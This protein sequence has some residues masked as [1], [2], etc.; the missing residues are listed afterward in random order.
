M[1][2]PVKYLH[3]G[4]HN[5]THGFSKKTVIIIALLAIA[6]VLVMVIP[7]YLKNVM[8]SVLIAKSLGILPSQ[9]S[10][11]N[12]I[13]GYVALLSY[14][15]GGYFA[16][17]VNLK[18]LTLFGLAAVGA[19]SIWYAFIPFINQGKIVQ[20][21]I[22][23]AAWSFIT[24]FIFWSALWKI[25][26]EQGKP[27][28]NGKLNGLHGSLNGLIGS[29]LIALAYLIFWLTGDIFAKHMGQYA[30]TSLVLFF[31]I[32]IFITTILLYKIVPDST[33]HKENNQQFDIKTFGNTLKNY[34]LWLA[35]FLI[36]GVYMLQSGLSV[37]VTYAQD[38]LKII[39]FIVVLAG[40]LRTYFFRFLFSSPAGKWADKTQ[41]YVLFI[42]IGLTIASM[43]TLT[44]ILLPGFGGDF[45][46]LNPVYQIVV[47][48][49][50]IILF[51]GLGIACWCL[52]T[53]RWATIYQIGINQKEYAVSV[54]FISF[55]A[56]SP[57]AWFWQVD[58]ILLKKFGAE[59][60]YPSNIIANQISLAVITSIALI[61]AVGGLILIF[62]L[63][64]EKKQQML[65]KQNQQL[66]TI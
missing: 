53:N 20:L 6:D 14:F 13:Y 38:A 26:A 36:M 35:T 66:A 5:F 55:I 3:K 37:V 43:L 2:S 41:N 54:G 32:I 49:L 10:Q 22:I 27:E 51:L 19:F 45:T 4:Y 34:K 63:N 50:V 24:C 52:V 18:K 7:F 30:F 12:A 31:T 15:V 47:Q 60:G 25:L 9:F 48:V 40:I 39:P 1:L 33:S 21:Y 57:D 58:S 42:T 56:F 44:M 61:A 46:K 64:Y 29:I 17:R 65:I 28:E 16:D 23:F 11:A 59:N 8:S 62:V